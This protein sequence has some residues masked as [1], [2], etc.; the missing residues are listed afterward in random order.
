[1]RFIKNYDT[2]ASN[3]N[4]KVVLELI[5]TA[6]AAIQPEQ[7]FN[8]NFSLQENMLKIRDKTVNLQ[9][10]ERVFLVGFGKG[11]AEMCRIIEST[12]GNKLTAGFDIDVIDAAP[13]KKVA[14]TKGT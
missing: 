11:S 1:M 8:N 10:F 2:L 7:V 9:N 14:Y 5:E 13:F 12:L 6:L 4:R 3:D